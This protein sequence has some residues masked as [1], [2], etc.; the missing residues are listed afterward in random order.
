MPGS[1][2]RSTN[3]L[4][5]LTGRGIHTVMKCVALHANYS[6]IDDM[7]AL[8]DEIADNTLVSYV[9]YPGIDGNALAAE[10]M[11]RMGDLVG[12]ALNKRSRLYFDRP[13]CQLC[14]YEPKRENVCTD[15]IW[16]LYVNPAGLVFPCIAIPESLGNWRE[17]F[18]R[19]RGLSPSFAERLVKWRKF[20]FSKILECGKREYCKYCYS[21]CPG[22]A[23]L[24]HGNAAVPAANHCR[25]AVARHVAAKWC[26]AGHVADEWAS[27]SA[28]GEA[29][30]AQVASLGI[31]TREYVVGGIV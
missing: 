14:R 8:G 9:F 17:V 11:L 24:L 18:A 15:C 30:K 31:P 5:L 6:E 7:L 16:S 25:L 29:V 20:P 28:D 1:F 2:E 26:E 27:I 23:L 21:A 22:D 3:A 4:R 12:L 10:Q 19:G 13:S